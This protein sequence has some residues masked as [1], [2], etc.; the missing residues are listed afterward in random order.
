MAV[1]DAHDRPETRKA[2][3]EGECIVVELKFFCRIVRYSSCPFNFGI[4]RSVTPIIII[5]IMFVDSTVFQCI[6]SVSHFYR[7]LL[8]LIGAIYLFVPN[9][10]R[11]IFL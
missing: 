9:F 3:P 4:F 5:S 7:A 10:T 8:G 11:N 6:F 2:R 1:A